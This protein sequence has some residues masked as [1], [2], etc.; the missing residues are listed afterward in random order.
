MDNRYPLIK[1][2]RIA[3]N[4]KYG[5]DPV[6]D[7]PP[8]PDAPLNTGVR[9]LITQSTHPVCLLRISAKHLGDTRVACPPHPLDDVRQ[10]GIREKSQ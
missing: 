6:L 8:I 4:M 3:W 10:R 5:F 1:Q 2:A 9:V 7:I